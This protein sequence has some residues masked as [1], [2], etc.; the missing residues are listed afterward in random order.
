MCERVAL[1]PKLKCKRGIKVNTFHFF[2]HTPNNLLNQ[3]TNS[4]DEK[5]FTIIGLCNL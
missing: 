2:I 3:T 1:W 5:I 4:I